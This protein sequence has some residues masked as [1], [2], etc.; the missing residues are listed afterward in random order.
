MIL[1]MARPDE[2]KNFH[3]LIKAY[4]QDEELIDLANLVLIIGTRTGIA[5]MK[6]HEKEVMQTVLMLI[7]EYDLYGNVSYPKQHESADVPEIYRMAVLSG[8]VFINPAVTEPFGLTL[9]EA[10]ATGLPLVATRD[11]GPREIIGKCLNGILVDP[12]D[13]LEMAKALKRILKSSTLWFG[14]SANGLAGVQDFFS[15]PVHAG[16]YLESLKGLVRSGSDISHT[17]DRRATGLLSHGKGLQDD[18]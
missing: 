15:W 5:H 16:T 6:K 8:G 18:R 11:G 2:R 9:L 3:T 13:P 4:G 14:L 7:D 10:A 1:A 17:K 12:L